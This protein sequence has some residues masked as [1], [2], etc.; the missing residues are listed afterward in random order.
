MMVGCDDLKGLF[1][2]WMG[3]EAQWHPCIGDFWLKAGRVLTNGENSAD[4]SSS[5]IRKQICIQLVTC[6]RERE[7]GP[8]SVQQPPMMCIFLSKADLFTNWNVFPEHEMTSFFKRAPGK[9]YKSIACVQKFGQV[10][11]QCYLFCTSQ[12]PVQL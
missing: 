11:L 5:N 1:K 10:F 6:R 3:K 8:P 7:K 12:P 9:Q 4:I 2:T